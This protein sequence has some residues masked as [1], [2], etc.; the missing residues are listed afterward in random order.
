M[1]CFGTTPPTIRSPNTNPVPDSPGSNSM[2]TC[3]NWP[4]P[5]VWRLKRLSIL[6]GLRIVSRYGTRGVPVFTAALHLRFSRSTMTSTCASPM[7]VRIVSPVPSSRRTWTDGSSSCSRAS[8]CPSLSR[9]AL[10]SGSMLTWSDG[11]GNS[12][13]GSSTA[14]ALSA[15]S[16]SPTVVLVS[17]AM[18]AMSPGPTCERFSWSLPWMARRFPT[19]SS[20]FLLALTTCPWLRSVPEM[21]RK[22][23]SRPTNGS[24]IVLNTCATNGAAGSGSRRLP[25]T[26]VRPPTSAGDGTCLAIMLSSSRTPMFLSALPTKTGTTLPSRVPLWSA[27]SISSSVSVSPSRYFIISS[28][29]ASAAASTSASRR[30]CSMPARSS[31]I[32]ASVGLPFS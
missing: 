3:P 9:S 2:T 20:S 18:A 15:T 12:K 5:P 25:S 30:E 16:V 28:S 29:L 13:R 27:A 32:G 31:G 10:L 23:V 11:A 26:V 1:Y 21:T 22:Q 24:E 19:R 8:A 4:C 7:A 14:C 17:F 6:A